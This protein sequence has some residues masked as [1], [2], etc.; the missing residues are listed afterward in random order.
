MRRMDY[1]LP[2]SKYRKIS[3]IRIRLKQAKTKLRGRIKTQINPMHEMKINSN[4]TYVKAT[5]P[6]RQLV[7]LSF[8]TSETDLNIDEK[9]RPKNQ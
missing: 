8:M 1:A 7:I 3:F 2:N 6:K 9:L 4:Y 5:F